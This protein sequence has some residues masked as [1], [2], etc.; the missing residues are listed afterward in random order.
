[1]KKRILAGIFALLLPLN[2]CSDYDEIDRYTVVAGIGIDPSAR[3]FDLCCETAVGEQGG[4]MA[5]QSRLFS[6]SG[7]TILDALRNATKISGEQL[8]FGHTQM[9]IL[10]KTALQGGVSDT[11]SFFRRDP[12]FE[13]SIRLAAAPYQSAEQILSASR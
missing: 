4:G 10:G 3:G 11:L 2:G 6:T 1:M 5:V 7:V 8:Y 9:I 13:V 12:D